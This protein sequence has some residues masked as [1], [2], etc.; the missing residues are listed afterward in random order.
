MREMESFLRLKV[1]TG[2]ELGPA[3]RAALVSFKNAEK[4]SRWKVE[5]LQEGLLC[6]P[7]LSSRASQLIVTSR[8]V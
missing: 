7:L 6:V 4:S 2:V 3:N 1:L 8:G 5:N